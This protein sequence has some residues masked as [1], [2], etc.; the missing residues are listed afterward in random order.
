MLDFLCYFS[1]SSQYVIN[2]IRPYVHLS[3][4]DISVG[5][6]CARVASLARVVDSLN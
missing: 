5:V 2:I 6:L 3:R 4:L 1:F